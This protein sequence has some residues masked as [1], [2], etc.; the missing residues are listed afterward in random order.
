[1]RIVNSVIAQLIKEKGLKDKKIAEMLSEN[2]ERT[3][4]SQLLGQYKNGKKKPGAEFILLW[5][6]TFPNDKIFDKLKVEETKVSR[7]TV[8]KPTLVSNQVEKNLPYEEEREILLRNL[9]TAGR[10]ND[11]LL[12]RIKELGG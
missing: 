10:L 12:K 8:E 5:D 7:E 2:A 9:D 6:E 1:M 11:Y 3:I 4:S